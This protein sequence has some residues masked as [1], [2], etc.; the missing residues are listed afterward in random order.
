MVGLGKPC[1]SATG[2]WVATSLEGRPV[3]I[4]QALEQVLVGA[5]LRLGTVQRIVE[6]VAFS[7]RAL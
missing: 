2:T 7:P 4:S 6:P 1:H 5:N 3:A